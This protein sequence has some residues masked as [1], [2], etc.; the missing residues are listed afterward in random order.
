MLL[1]SPLTAAHVEQLTGKQLTADNRSQ[2]VADLYSTASY[3]FTSQAQRLC[4][5]EHG[6]D[7]EGHPKCRRACSAPNKLGA[8][9]S[10]CTN[11]NNV[12]A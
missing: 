1:T 8:V 7:G 12:R 3:N 10:E 2:S 9:G 5:D 4:P 11:D 6:T